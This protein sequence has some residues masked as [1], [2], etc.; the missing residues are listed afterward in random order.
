M[1]YYSL[2]ICI[3]I[4]V[5]FAFAVIIAYREGMRD[6]DRWHKVN[7]TNMLSVNDLFG[8]EDE[9]ENVEIEV[10]KDEA[11]FNVEEPALPTY[12][13][14]VDAFVKAQEERGVVYS[15]EEIEEMKNV[16]EVY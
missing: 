3:A 7:D 12:E 13:E 5:F 14:E 16:E 1:D 9:E 2:A 4:G 11:E 8:D 6:C 15:T 10:V